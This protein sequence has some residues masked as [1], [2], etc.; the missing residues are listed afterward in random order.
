MYLSELEEIVAYVACIA[1][2]I[3]FGVSTYMEI[4]NTIREEKEKHLEQKE[5]E[6]KIK[7]LISYFNTKKKL[8]DNVTK[9]KQTLNQDK[10][11]K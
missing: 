3:G 9:L 11:K 4:K 1:I 8:L 6:E 7:T 10:T 5:N 2:V